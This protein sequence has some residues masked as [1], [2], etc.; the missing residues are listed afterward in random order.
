ML[1]LIDTLCRD[2]LT[3]RGP[4]GR[5]GGSTVPEV[6]IPDQFNAATFFVDRNVAEGREDKVAILS[7]DREITYRQVLEN[8][9]RTGNMLRQ[10]G[11]QPE[12]RVMLLLLDGPE[13]AYAFF[14]A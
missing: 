8:V 9:N 4:S 12:Q 11:V 13:F 1:N 14:G 3:A 2:T 10:F 7:G 6:V 5:T